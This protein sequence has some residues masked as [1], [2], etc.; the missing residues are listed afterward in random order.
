MLINESVYMPVNH[1]ILP[2]EWNGKFLFSELWVDPDAGQ[3]DENG[4]KR[5][6]T[7]LLFKIDVQP[8]GAFDVLMVSVDKEVGM[9]IFCPEKVLPFSGQI[10]QTLGQIL[11]RNGL[12][13]GGVSVRKMQRPL[14][15]TEV[16]PQ[17]FER[18]NSVNVKV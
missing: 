4:R 9:N 5:R 6:C 16:F 12:K 10:E 11:E 7:K 15:L 3:A 2:L 17:I 13:N 8:L 14:T 1:F 18:K